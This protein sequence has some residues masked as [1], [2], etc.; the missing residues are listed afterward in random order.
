MRSVFFFLTA[1]ALSMVVTRVA[2]V[3]LT[4]TGLSRQAARFQARSAFSGAGFTT[5]EAESVVNHP[6]RRRI[7]MLLILMGGAG[8]VTSLATLVLSLSR[9]EQGVAGRVPV[10][11]VVGVAALWLIGGNRTVDRWVSRLFERLLDRFTELELRDY[12]HLLHLA[13]EWKIGELHIEDG[14]WIAGAALADLD[15]P[16]EGVV[17]LGVQRSDGRYVG[18]PTR[19]TRL[20]PSDTVLLYGQDRTIDELDRRQTGAAGDDA[21]DASQK[22]HDAL[23][24]DQQQ[25]E[26]AA[27]V[28]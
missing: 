3:A 7:V 15:L 11:L 23:V 9:I 14:D 5:D 4:M 2:T 17:V 6:V 25:R 13:D 19:R 28:L 21:H 1:V 22:R 10:V 24:E 12:E 20:Q 26:R 27:G 16:E 8:L 18:A